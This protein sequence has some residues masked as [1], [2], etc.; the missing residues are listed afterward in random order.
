MASRRS[1]RKKKKGGA[2]KTMLA[3]VC[4]LAILGGGG[5]Y[6][7]Q[8]GT[9]TDSEDSAV[10]DLVPDL[11]DDDNGSSD[12][13]PVDDNHMA[14]IENEMASIDDRIY[15]LEGAER[16][17]AMVAD[18]TKLAKT[19]T[20]PVPSF[21]ARN[22][23][24]VTF[25]ALTD[26]LF[27]GTNHNKF[28]GNYVVKSGDSFDKIA[29]K[30]GCSMG[31]VYRLNGIQAGST[32]LHPGDNLKV[33]CGKPTVVVRKR[34]FTTSVYLGDYLV[35][36]YI[37]AHGKNNNTPLG[38]TSIISMTKHPEETAQG[39]NDPV[40][41]MKL[42]WVGLATFGGNRSGIG[43]HGTQYPE[44]IPGLTSRGCMRMHDSDVVELY[45]FI[46]IGN[47]VEVRA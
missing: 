39:P 43:F 27:L 21:E 12:G 19:L 18:Y 20:G 17:T 44:S 6:M 32:N 23:I 47:K 7:S 22:R 3:V 36:Q 2:G 11:F 29:R 30:H 28:N 31:L 25:H 8:D 9:S 41:E 1:R 10:A 14:N 26:E 33:P 35:R 24:L 5:W 40:K 37:V 45:D 42:R 46:R 15:T 16:E 38:K 13:L 4:V 34:D